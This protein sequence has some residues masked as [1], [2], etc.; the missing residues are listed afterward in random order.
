MAGNLWLTLSVPILRNYSSFQRILPSFQHILPS[1]LCLLSSFPRR[2]ESI[3]DP[4]GWHGLDARLRGHDEVLA[5]F[6]GH[7]EARACFRGCDEAL[8]RHHRESLPNKV[9]TAEYRT[10]LSDEKL[11][12]PELEKGVYLL[13]DDALTPDEAI[14]DPYVLEFLSLR[15]K[16]TAIRQANAALLPAMLERLF[17]EA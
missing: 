1:F 3:P 10:A 11:L 5:H 4:A 12:G 17:R 14:K 9:L 7:D 2:R 13:L 6:C 15:A 16:H 8:A